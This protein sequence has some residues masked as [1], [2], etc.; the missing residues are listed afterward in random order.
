M[1]WQTL[2]IE[3]LPNS[4]PYPPSLLTRK[5]LFAPGIRQVALGLGRMIC[6]QPWQ[7]NKWGFLSTNAG[8]SV[9]WVHD[10]ASWSRACVIV[11]CID[12]ADVSTTGCCGNG[13]GQLAV[14]WGPQNKTSLETKPESAE[15]LWPD[16]V[17]LDP[18]N[19]FS[20]EEEKSRYSYNVYTLW[21]HW[22][23]R[24]IKI[25]LVDSSCTVCGQICRH[26]SD[27]GPEAQRI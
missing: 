12:R 6:Y 7:V 11:S 8:S 16:E 27:E 15:P 21:Y 17:P 5:E 13:R 23:R 3:H 10:C 2:L 1:S 9:T 4:H 26:Y 19:L 20:Q 24:F 14:S 25:I 18:Q 22:T